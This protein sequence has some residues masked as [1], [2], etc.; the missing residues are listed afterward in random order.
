MVDINKAFR[1]FGTVLSTQLD[2]GEGRLN[3]ANAASLELVHWL[4]HLMAIYG[5]CDAS[6]IL[7]GARASIV[8][9]LAYVGM[10]L[11]R[12]ALSAMRTQADLFLAFSYFYEHPREWLGVCKFS[13]GFMLRGDIEK[14]HRESIPDYRKKI[15]VLDQ[16]YEFTLQDVY[17]ILSA[18]IHGQS[19]FTLPTSHDFQGLVS[20]DTFLASVV[21]LQG[22]LSIALSNVLAVAF[23]SDG[24]QP[25]PTTSSRIQ[26]KLTVPQLGILYAKSG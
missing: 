21:A 13:R 1:E 8:E 14:Y 26:A 9:T 6:E 7:M 20:S 4:D 3:D 16:A 12:G 18:H 17:R 11:G 22:K 24:I 2:N 23:L 15:G 10:G 19:S 5:S 25:P